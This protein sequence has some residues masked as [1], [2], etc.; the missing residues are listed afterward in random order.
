MK[1][2]NRYS[3]IRQGRM[4]NDIYGQRERENDE[5]GTVERRKDTETA[6]P[7]SDRIESK[8]NFQCFMNS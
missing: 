6:D 8:N 3:N 5:I 4:N 1:N 7:L 2:M